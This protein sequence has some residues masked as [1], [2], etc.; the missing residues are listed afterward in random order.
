MQPLT[1]CNEL[2]LPQ[3]ENGDHLTQPTFHS[4][5]EAM[6][7][8]FRAEL[9]GGIVY[10]GFRV[11]SAHG[12][13]TARLLHWL[14]IYDQLTPGVEAL[15][16]TTI[17]LGEFSEPEPDACLLV[18]P[19]RGGTARENADGYLQGPPELIVEVA[20]S[21]ESLDLHAKKR[22]YETAGVPEYI[23]VA[24]RQQRVFWFVLRGGS[25]QEITAETDG[26]LRS[27]IFP[28]LWLDPAALLREDRQRLREVLQQ[29]L[30]TP[31]HAA[32]VARLQGQ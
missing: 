31:Q 15:A 17:L 22:D 10:L 12:R 21:T 26:I 32:F 1:V 11:T 30:A 13:M 6:P 8:D 2:A 7:E 27:G 4:R 18:R 24:L 19:E 14:G 3:L 23:V 28:G 5:Y 9:I 20:S 25:Y 29:G 16:R